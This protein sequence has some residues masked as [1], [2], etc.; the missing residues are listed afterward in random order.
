MMQTPPRAA[1]E[2]RNVFHSQPILDGEGVESLRDASASFAAGELHIIL[3]GIASGKKVLFRMA[4]LQEAPAEGEI[5]IE[6]A[7]TGRLTEEER[8][9]IRTH[10][11]GFVFSSS[12]LLPSFLAIENVVMPL[13]RLTKIPPE[14][15]RERAEDALAFV[16]LRGHEQV[17]TEQLSEA[18]QYRVALARAL[19]LRPALV[20][21][22]ELD[23]RFSGE[24]LQAEVALL[25]RACETYG[26]AIIATV[27]PGAYT[28]SRVRWIK[29][30]DGA[31]CVDSA[32]G[33]NG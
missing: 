11:I 23:Q 17:A 19:A 25:R 14:E 24:A 7:P 13:F 5:V 29:V 12:F 1:L 30:E 26:V 9:E 15:A 27:G 21:V 16:G 2:L 10:R 31:I 18:E 22:E 3:G 32:A 6:G 20:L 8:V 33:T 28:A 4:G